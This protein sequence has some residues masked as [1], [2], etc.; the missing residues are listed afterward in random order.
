MNARQTANT[1][2]ERNDRCHCGS[3]LRYKKCCLKSDM[4]ITQSEPFSTRKIKKI[5][6]GLK[7]KAKQLLGNA[8]KVLFINPDD[9]EIIKMSEVIIEFADEF[10]QEMFTKNQR[11]IILELACIAWNIGIFIDKSRQLSDL[12]EIIDIMKIQDNETKKVLKYIL[13][14]LI[15]KKLTQ[16]SSID[17]LIVSYQITET[18]EDLR[19]DVA[20]VLSEKELNISNTKLQ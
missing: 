13:S 19:I 20:S 5:Q 10:L 15:N 2:L 6:A 12:N 4:L 9:Q 8:K 7:E 3:H 11:K 16:Y 1:K 17:R 18:G 14:M